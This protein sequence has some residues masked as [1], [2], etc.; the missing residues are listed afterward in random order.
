M[1]FFS[2][3]FTVLKNIKTK[4]YI[5]L[6]QLIC[7][8]ASGTLEKKK[9]KILQQQ[10]PAHFQLYFEFNDTK[11]FSENQKSNHKLITKIK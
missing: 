1:F 5:L 10:L 8:L 6:S 9:I 7:I 3:I 4:N 11:R 2:C